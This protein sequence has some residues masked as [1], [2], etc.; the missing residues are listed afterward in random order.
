VVSPSSHRYDRVTKLRGYAQL[1][2]P[3]Y[4]LVDGSARTLERLVLREGTYAIAM[5][6]A[7]DETFRPDSFDGLEI[8]LSELWG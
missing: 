7:E 2:V 1:G 3:E 8:P 4:W 6:L 5:S